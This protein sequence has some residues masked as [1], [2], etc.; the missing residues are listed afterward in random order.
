MKIAIVSDTHLTPRVTA[1]GENWAAVRAWIEA[2]APDLVVNLGD[3]SADGATHPDELDSARPAF[4]GLRSEMRFVPGNHDIGD[5]PLE[6]GGPTD[7]PVDLDR[8]AHYR[9][10]FGPDWWSLDC[11]AWQIVALNA[12]LFATGTGAEAE[13]LAWLEERLGE[14][15]GPLGVLLHK[16]LFRNGP[17]DAEVHQ[18]YVPARPR[19]RLLTALASRDLRFVASGHAHQ[20]RRLHVDGVEHVWAPSTAYCMPDGMQERV[21][22]KIVGLVTIDLRGDGHRVETVVPAGLVRHNILDHPHTY[23]KLE[24]VKARLGD[25]AALL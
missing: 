5:N 19:R 25:R 23:A 9:R 20:A 16:P 4:A 13:Q 1:F 11:G 12:Q 21:G 3:I 18:R 2:A 10:L 8:L 24:G 6:P 17:G 22:E 15:R 14:R 7:H